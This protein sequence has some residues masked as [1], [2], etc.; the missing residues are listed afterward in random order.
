MVRVRIGPSPTGDP[1]VGTAYIALFNYVFAKKH[2]GTFILRIEDT[3]QVRSKPAWETMLVDA[4]KWL[5]LQWAEGPDCGGPHGPYRQSERRAIY[6]EHVQTLVDR[7][8]A[9]P[10]FCSAE[11]LEQLRVQQRQR[12]VASGYDGQCR[13]LPPDEAARR[14]AAGEAHV[15]RLKVPQERTLQFVDKLRGPLQFE[16]HQVDDQVL[17]KSDGMP[18]YHLA[19]V[20]D[21]HLMGIT[22]VIRAEE[23]I[24]ST[25]KH[26]LLYE[27]FGWQ[28]PQF[29]HMP[30]LRN[31]DKSKIS[32]RKN[33]VSL[34]YYR[35]AGYLPEAMLN[36]L[37]M[38]GWTMPDGR[39]KFTVDDMVEAFDFERISLGGPVFDV[40]KLTW[41]NGLYIRASSPAEMV[42]RWRQTVLTDAAL[43]AVAPLV[44]ERI[45]KLEDLLEHTAYFFG[46]EVS[47]DAA[48]LR[49]LVPKNRTPQAARAALEAVLELIDAQPELFAED[50]EA[51]MRAACTAL[52]WKTKELFMPVRVA[53]TG[54]RATPPLFETMAHLGKERCRRRLR[55]AIAQ[56]KAMPEAAPA[57]QVGG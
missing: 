24:T 41:L 50:L 22:H 31:P 9:Y 54:R 38:M 48:A 34:N 17:I 52:A 3:D 46:G 32:K 4:L 12:G 14:L 33:P 43:N 47:Y 45:E 20:V 42:A 40:Q 18:T 28:P 36:Y 7:G 27:G 16:A 6:A 49:D 26:V 13:R 8:A 10:C 5:G 37:A 39:E 21:D 56:L 55:A 19:N 1:H 25:P 30:L 51:K 15:I 53:V 35:Q 23:W 44:H 11:R 57:A 2:N 29:V